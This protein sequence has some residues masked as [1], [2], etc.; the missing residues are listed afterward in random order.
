MTSHNILADF[1]Q[2]K[3]FWDFKTVHKSLSEEKELSTEFYR[4]FLETRLMLTKEFQELGINKSKAVNYAQNYLNKLLLVFFVEDNVSLRQRLFE[5]IVLNSFRRSLVSNRS[6]LV[7][8]SINSLFT[9]LAK[10]LNDSTDF[11]SID[12]FFNVKFSN[13]LSFRDLRDPSYF[14]NVNAKPRKNVNFNEQFEEIFVKYENINP[15]IKN[16]LIMASYNFKTEISV[17]ILGYIF[18]KS[19]NDL[20]KIP[21]KNK[22]SYRK[23]RG[24]FYTPEYIAGYICQS[25]ILFYLSK[26]EATTLDGLIYEYLDNIDELE[27]KLEKIKVLDPACGSGVF[28][29]QAVDILLEIAKKIKLA[30]YYKED[31]NTVKREQK[32][33]KYQRYALEKWRGVEVKKIIENNIFGVDINEN[34]VQL[35]KLTLL[36][37][38]IKEIQI[39]DNLP[40]IDLTKNIKCGNS[41]IDDFDVAGAKAFKWSK[42]FKEISQKGGFDII[43]GNPPYVNIIVNV[44][45]RAYYKKKYPEIYTGKN[46]LYYFFFRKAIELC[47]NEGYIA[48]IA[49]RYLMEAYKAQKIRHYIRKNTKIKEIIDFSNFKIFADA[50]IDTATYILNKTH[51]KI[52]MEVYQLQNKQT[53]APSYFRNLSLIQD[54][55]SDTKWCFIDDK[56]VALLKKIQDN[57]THVLDQIAIISKGVQT[58]KDSVFVV[59]KA[60]IDI[61]SLESEVLRKWIKNSQIKP[62]GVVESDLWIIRSNRYTIQDLSNFPNLKKYLEQNKEKLMKRARVNRWFHWRT[63]DERSTIDWN[64]KKIISPYKS[65]YNNFTID[66]NQSYFSQDVVLIIPKDNQLDL[67]FLLAFLNSKLCE[68]YFKIKGKKLGRLY[69]YYPKQLGQIPI[70][71]ISLKQQSLIGEKARKMLL[72][73]KKT[74]ELKLRSILRIQEE[75]KSK[76]IRK[77]LLDTDLITTNELLGKIENQT[78]IK[79]SQ[80]QKIQIE[81][82]IT[83]KMS[84]IQEL[85]SKKD[86]TEKKINQMIYELY[87]L[88]K[89]EITAIRSI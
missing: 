74:Y 81:D 75:L 58:G 76:E 86:Q 77:T 10:T 36:L 18:E 2:E 22:T 38:M 9:N 61:H 13:L 11:L 54:S 80:K 64:A 20:E 60:I 44:Q 49:P 5:D 40:R 88:T 89:E 26:T 82:Y 47:K 65:A 43:V 73:N 48:F 57:S 78:K 56:S 6:K 34:S 23:K 31:Y 79:L 27:N 4:L 33:K 25:T 71:H 51:K 59:D 45:N 32:T 24:V 19:I 67:Y 29:I 53:T 84:K 37:K 87:G 85:K 15:I 69:E 21:D 62:Y 12:E 14:I 55:L 66:F 17:N 42:E 7:S 50:N 63:G 39:L 46:D 70:K 83:D 35:T 16:L 52:K 68:W 30:K 1:S 3:Q 41:L 8:E 28:L 72:F